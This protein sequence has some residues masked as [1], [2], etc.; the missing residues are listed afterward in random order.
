MSKRSGNLNELLDVYLTRL[1]AGDAAPDDLLEQSSQEAESLRPLLAVASKAR[2][3]L[4][5]RAP[6][7]DFARNSELR[8]LKRLRA[9]RSEALRA[10]ADRSRPRF[11]SMRA[12]PALVSLLLVTALL[13]GMIGVV[14]VSAASLPGDGLYPLKRGLEETRLALTF[15]ASGD[16]QLLSEYSDER[17]REI[18]A[19]TTAERIEDINAAVEEYVVT[20]DRLVE[21]SQDITST[22]GSAYSE[23]VQEKLG[24]HIEVLQGVQAKVPP[25]AQA[26]IQR[27]IERSL[28]QSKKKLEQQQENEEDQESKRE[29]Q[30]ERREEREQERNLRHAEQIAR[31]HDASPDEVL[32]IFEGICERDWKCVRDHYRD[33]KGK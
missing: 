1:Q 3:A 9:R 17:L 31:K 23:G 10:K 6:D 28:Q 4:Y 7:A 15:D 18:E 27:A 2:Q 11:W 20:I 19:L 33:D 8:L 12:V 32:A 22:E 5:P 29:E 13:L 25:Q 14:R 16:A 30:E 24:H 26:A 21:A